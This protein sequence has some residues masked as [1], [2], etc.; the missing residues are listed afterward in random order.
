MERNGTIFSDERVDVRRYHQS[1]ERRP[2]SSQV[3]PNS[4][5]RASAEPF[6][7]RLDSDSDGRVTRRELSGDRI[8]YPPGD[9]KIDPFSSSRGEVTAFLREFSLAHES[10]LRT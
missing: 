4:P 3:D 9:T 6:T 10:P 1:Q 2:E 5:S 8:F 7:P